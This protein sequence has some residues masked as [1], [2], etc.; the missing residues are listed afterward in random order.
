MVD[1][2]ISQLPETSSLLP[3]DT[4]AGVQNGVTVKFLVSA[5]RQGLA[6]AAQG[7]KADSAVQPNSPVFTESLLVSRNNTAGVEATLR[8]TAA[9]APVIH[10]EYRNESTPDGR[11]LA[12][13]LIGAAGARPWAGVDWTAH[14]AAA[15][16]FGAAEDHTASTQATFINLSIT[17]YG[18]TVASRYPAATF[19]ADGDIINSKGLTGRM[20]NSGERGRGVQVLRQANAEIS[21]A[22]FGNAAFVAFY[23]GLVAGGTPSAPAAT[24]ANAGLGFGLIG[25]DGTNYTGAKGIVGVLAAEAYT[26]TANGTMVVIETTPK[27][28]LGRVRQVT[29]LPEGGALLANASAVPSTPASGGVFYVENGALKYKGSSGTVTV[30]APA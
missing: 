26:P 21:V 24:A 30:I 17:P 16:H 15:Y 5:I 11:P 19:N 10:Y 12:N 3:T 6:T 25:H 29:I 7:A 4:V 20:V 8:T 9:N 2:R 18:S 27:G 14:S 28:S 22:S 13:Q 1:I 23:R